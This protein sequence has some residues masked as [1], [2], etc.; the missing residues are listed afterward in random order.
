M[1]IIDTQKAIGSASTVGS[2]GAGWSSPVARQAHNLKVGGSNPS[3]ASNSRAD[4]AV[5][6]VTFSDGSTVQTTKR[7]RSFGFAWCAAGE[8]KSGKTW[9]MTGFSLSEDRASARMSE[10][11]RHIP[12]Q[13]GKITFRDVQPV[14]PA[15]SA[16]C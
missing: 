13:G 5:R 9:R 6:V 4:S 10:T 16:S 3:P 8:L 11:V 14:P 12:R 7:T 15:R 1:T 2:I